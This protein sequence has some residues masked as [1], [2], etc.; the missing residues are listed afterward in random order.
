MRKLFLVLSLVGPSAQAQTTQTAFQIQTDFS[1]TQMAY[2]ESTG[3]KSNGFLAGARLELGMTL[4]DSVRFGIS[5]RYQAGHLNFKGDT[6]LDT[7]VADLSRDWAR[8]L[9][10]GVYFGTGTSN[11]FIG[12]GRRLWSSKIVDSFKRESS[13]DYMPI[14]VLYGMGGLYI[15]GEYRHWIKGAATSEL[16]AVDSSRSDVEVEQDKGGGYA[17]EIGYVFVSQSVATRLALTYE[18]WSVDPSSSVSD[19]IATQQIPENET[20]LLGFVIGITL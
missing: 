8:D 18:K 7:D 9:R 17:A 10:A 16:S 11:L 3:A 4:A 5:G 6:W 15:A 14:R 20:T 2:E 12:Y 13:I 1:Y 19:G